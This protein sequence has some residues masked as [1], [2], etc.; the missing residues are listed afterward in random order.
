MQLKLYRR[1]T[2][3]LAAIITFIIACSVILYSCRELWAGHKE[4]VFVP[5]I[6]LVFVLSAFYVWYD[7]NCDRRI[8]QKMADEGHIALAQIHEG[9]FYRIIRNARMQ[10]QVLWKLKATVYDH[11]HQPHEV[12]FIDRFAP[13]QTSIPE[14]TVYVTY[15]PAQPEVL[16]IV[17]NVLLSAYPELQETVEGYEKDR[18]LPIS[19]L[20]VYYDKGLIIKTFRETI[21]NQKKGGNK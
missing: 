2:L 12:E 15:D 20:N 21:K 4:L 7:T 6:I 14:G 11:D 10:N 1:S 17:P 16:F 5:A 19:Y 8:I 3:L 9:T 13:S 18:K